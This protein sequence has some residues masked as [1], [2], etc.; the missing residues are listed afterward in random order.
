MPDQEPPPIIS[1]ILQALHQRRGKEVTCRAFTPDDYALFARVDELSDKL[2]ELEL[3][4][5]KAREALMDEARR[6]YHLAREL[7]V[8]KH[9]VDPARLCVHIET[10]PYGWHLHPEG[11]PEHQVSQAARRPPPDWAAELH[12]KFEAGEEP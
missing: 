12:K 7:F 6:E 11:S 3:E 8:A 9:Q 5:Q 1:A 10:K 2:V 4:H